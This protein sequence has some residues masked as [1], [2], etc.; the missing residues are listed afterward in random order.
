MYP[1]ACRSYKLISQQ[2]E[3]PHPVWVAAHVR[4]VTLPV[5][6]NEDFY[7]IRSKN[8]TDLLSHSEGDGGEGIIVDL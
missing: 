7:R 5:N 2:A 6:G 4:R 8:L 1:A 3:A